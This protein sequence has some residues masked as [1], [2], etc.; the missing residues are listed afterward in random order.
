MVLC[1]YSTAEVGKDGIELVLV[2][3]V[4]VPDLLRLATDFQR[5]RREDLEPRMHDPMRQ[6]LF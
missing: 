1:L 5:F 4:N 3:P 6:S 2:K